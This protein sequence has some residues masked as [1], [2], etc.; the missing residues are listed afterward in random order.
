MNQSENFSLKGESTELLSLILEN[1]I[2]NEN[3]CYWQASVIM[4]AKS[5]VINLKGGKSV[6]VLVSAN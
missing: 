2:A 5:V 1:W 3:K 4:H 6:S